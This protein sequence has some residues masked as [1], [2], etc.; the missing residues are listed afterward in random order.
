MLELL[1]TND[2]VFLSFAQALLTDAGIEHFV[3]DAGMNNT[4]G[5]IGA[6][7]RRLMIAA[8][9]GPAARRVLTESGYGDTLAR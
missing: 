7:P 8:D 9:D 3:F 6:F 5:A 4:E 1:R 2:L